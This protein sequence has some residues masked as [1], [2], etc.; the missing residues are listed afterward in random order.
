MIG[1]YQAEKLQNV[2]KYSCFKKDCPISHYLGGS[3]GPDGV[4]AAVILAC[5]PY[6]FY[7]WFRSLLCTGF[8]QGAADG[9]LILYLYL[10]ITFSSFLRDDSDAVF[11]GDP[12]WYLINVFLYCYK[13]EV[14]H[15]NSYVTCF[16][17]VRPLF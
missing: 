16:S 15:T 10:R 1:L 8:T 4:F 12:L 2:L 17:Q 7:P 3:S 5:G 9:W 6:V 11:G 13:L 14:G